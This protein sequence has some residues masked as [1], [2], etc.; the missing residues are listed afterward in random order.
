MPQK[1]SP[2]Q[3]AAEGLDD[4][5]RRMANF[6]AN[7]PV[8]VSYEAPK[9]YLGRTYP[10]ADRISLSPEMRKSIGVLM[11]A[12]KGAGGPGQIEGLA[13]LIHEALHTR[14]PDGK[15]TRDPSTGFYSADDEWQAHQLSYNLVADAM[16]R[17]FGVDPNS[18]LGRRYQ[19]AAQGRGYGGTLGSPQA[20]NVQGDVFG[21]RTTRF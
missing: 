14:G 5:V 15:G 21:N 13:T 16:Q 8:T 18:R 2:G 20:A 4:L 17:F 1:P 6:Y 12:A 10:G 3:S 19:E 11:A 7:K 9:G